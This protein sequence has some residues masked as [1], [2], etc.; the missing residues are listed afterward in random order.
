MVLKRFLNTKEAS[1]V[2]TLDLSYDF[3]YYYGLTYQILKNSKRL[4]TG[5][6]KMPKNMENLIKNY[7]KKINKQEEEEYFSMVKEID[8]IFLKYYNKDGTRKEEYEKK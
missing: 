6:E 5:L 3:N 8:G 4:T 7:L 1:F 2:Q